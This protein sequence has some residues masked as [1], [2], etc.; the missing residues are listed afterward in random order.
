LKKSN[1]VK[2]G[3]RAKYLLDNIFRPVKI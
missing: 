2:S 3:Y 1:G